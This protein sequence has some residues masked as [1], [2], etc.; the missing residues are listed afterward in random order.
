MIYLDNNAT[1]AMDPLVIDLIAAE[2]RRGPSNPSSQHSVGRR[3]NECLDDAVQRIGACLGSDLSVP[4]GPRL[5][6]TS[7]GTESNNLALAGLSDDDSAPLVVS[8][9]E[10]A[11]VLGYAKEAILRGRQVHFL[12]VTS[13]GVVKVDSLRKTLSQIDSTRIQS[14]QPRSPKTLVAVMSANNETGVIQPIREIYERLSRR[15]RI[16]A[17]RCDTIDWQSSRHRF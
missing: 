5:I 16:V 17:C 1:T 10:H 13:G 12:P 9:I 6:L 3:A 11:S 8:S 14:D 7:G 15:R 2:M 4:G